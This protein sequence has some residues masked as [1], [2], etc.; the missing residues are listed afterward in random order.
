MCNSFVDLAKLVLELGNER[1][2]VRG[3]QARV[4]RYR[5]RRLQDLKLTAEVFPR[6][7]QLFSQTIWHWRFHICRSD[8]GTLSN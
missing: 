6:L 3:D 8:R 1:A 7:D 2:S 4:A 5:G